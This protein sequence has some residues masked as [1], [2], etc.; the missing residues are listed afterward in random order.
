MAFVGMA[1]GDSAAQYHI[2]SQVQGMIGTDGAK[3]VRTMIAQAQK[4]APGIFASIVGVLTLL[5]G[6]SGVFGELR[7]ALN[8]I[9]EVKPAGGSGIVGLV[10][11]RIFSFGMVLAIGFAS[12]PCARRALVGG[13][14]ATGS[15][16]RSLSHNSL[17][18]RG[19][20]LN[21]PVPPRA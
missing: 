10:K 9:W 14:A 7:S 16:E 13:L 19:W 2:I 12:T 3:A 20:Y 18:G 21:V 11:E 4:P 8:K 17:L 6:A 1:F 15:A 5:F